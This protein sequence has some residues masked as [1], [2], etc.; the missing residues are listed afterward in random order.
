MMKA[1]RK[2]QACLDLCTNLQTN[3]YPNATEDKDTEL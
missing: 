3:L 2:S 1:G